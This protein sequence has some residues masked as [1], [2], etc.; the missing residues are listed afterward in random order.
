MKKLFYL[1]FLTLFLF[2][3]ASGP[4]ER[5][6]NQFDDG[7]LEQSQE[8]LENLLLDN[9][10]EL[11]SATETENYSNTIAQI[12]AL[13]DKSDIVAAYMAISWN[14]YLSGDF[15]QAQTNLSFLVNQF[16]NSEEAPYAYI[17][18]AYSQ[19]Q[20]NKYEESLDTFQKVFTFYRDSIWAEYALYMLGQSHFKNYQFREAIK[21]YN[22]LTSFFSN[23]DF[24]PVARYEMAESY[25]KL[26]R[27]EKAISNFNICY[28]EFPLSKQAPIAGFRMAIF[29]EGRSQIKK[30]ESLL[31]EIISKYPETEIYIKIRNQLAGIYENTGREELALE[32]YLD[33]IN[34]R[35][36]DPEADYAWYSLAQGYKSKGENERALYY[37]QHFFNNHK[38]SIYRENALEACYDLA[39][40]MD[41]LQLAEV[42]GTLLILDYPNNPR[43]I[44]LFPEL[45]KTSFQ[46]QN[47]S[48]TFTLSEVYIYNELVETDKR[49]SAILNHLD[50]NERSLKSEDHEIW[51]YR[52]YL[53]LAPNGDN[54]KLEFA[55]ALL[56]K[57]DSGSLN[58]PEIILEAN[59]GIYEES[60]N[61]QEKAKAGFK[62]AQLLESKDEE[63]AIELYNDAAKIDPASKQAVTALYKQT[64]LHIKN[65][66]KSGAIITA[67]KLT[68][69]YPE[70]AE[71]AKVQV[72]VGNYL[73][74]NGQAD[75]AKRYYQST[76][77]G[78]PGTPEA[79]EAKEQLEKLP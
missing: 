9:D 64:T 63:R 34:N 41:E 11:I 16:P 22:N 38:K 36:D 50:F 28:Q 19:R 67:L 75:Q 17:L 26:R 79:Q 69:N 73:A 66:N 14:H 56:N 42:A 61:V 60:K 53:A 33:I 49:L 48:N 3:C 12:N 4:L 58:N 70:H 59:L 45:I 57:N 52:Q 55:K 18:L 32:T 5:S 44:E 24:T 37:F 20:L 7:K 72:L 35:P 65:D 25:Y 46:N 51:A 78:Y 39:K 6:I 62:A 31:L 8:T 2:S 23:S 76:I 1:L 27:Y 29:Y 15:Q 21:S 43:S 30:A 10:L 77:N 74:E 54:K 71:T 47:Y 40:T 68:Q 13:E